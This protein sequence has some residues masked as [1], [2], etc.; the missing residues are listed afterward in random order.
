M[1]VSYKAEIYNIY[2][3]VKCALA[4]TLSLY[5]RAL[6][7]VA[8]VIYFNWDDICSIKKELDKLS[9]I[10]RL[11]HTTKDNTAKYKSFDCLFYKMPA[12]IR[13]DIIKVA[14]GH[15]SSYMSNLKNYQVKR[16]NAISNG[17][18]FKELPPKLNLEPNIMP[19]FYKDA[20]YKPSDD[21]SINLKLYNGKT[22]EYFK[23]PLK[24]TDCKYLKRFDKTTFKNP[25]LQF[26]NNKFYIKYI[27][28]TPDKLLKTKLFPYRKILAVDLGINTHATCVVMNSDGTVIARKFITDTTDKD[29]LNFLLNKKRELQSMSGRWDY[30]PL[31]HIQHKIN[32]YNT[33]IENFVSHEIIRFALDYDV[34]VIVFEHL[35]KFKGRSSEKIHYW[36]KKAIVKKVSYKAHFYGMRYSTVSPFNTS[37]LAYDGSGYV[38]RGD[39]IKHPF[40]RKHK[41]FAK[42]FSICKFKNKKVYNCDLNAAYNIGARYS[43]R[44]YC[45]DNPDLDKSQSRVILSDIWELAG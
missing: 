39:S 13:R 29:R 21:N 9:Y 38:Q 43:Y 34:D 26:K 6:N 27:I 2:K 41:Y 10:E 23:L 28:E 7:Y 24:S 16:Y 33:A 3:T 17:K 37:R 20:M 35:S 4:D 25:Q 45:K 11:I 8:T 5:K 22:W 19:T 44:E 1:V 40:S 42:S 14:L 31:T 12:Y 32:C 30:A 15:V 18:K 36:R